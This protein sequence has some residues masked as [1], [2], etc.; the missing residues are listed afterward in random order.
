MASN[1]THH[2]ISASGIRTAKTLRTQRFARNETTDTYARLSNRWLGTKTDLCNDG[3]RAYT[4]I[5]PF[6][7]S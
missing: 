7:S 6:V 1:G 3:I 4:L 5:V 2:R